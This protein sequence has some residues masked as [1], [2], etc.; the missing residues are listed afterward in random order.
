[1]PNVALR[2]TDTV[3]LHGSIQHVTDYG[4]LFLLTVPQPCREAQPAIG[5]RLWF[6]QRW[7]RRTVATDGR[8]ILE[9]PLAALN[10]RI[11]LL[12]PMQK[13]WRQ[14]KEEGIA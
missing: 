14:Q 9:V 11:A 12:S 10:E 4:V 13:S 1:M 7:V 6:P 8:D 5:H 2:P 3:A